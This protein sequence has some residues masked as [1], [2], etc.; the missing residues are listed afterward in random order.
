MPFARSRARQHGYSAGRSR[1]ATAARSRS[2]ATAHCCRITAAR[3]SRADELRA[4]LARQFARLRTSP[5][6]QFARV[7]VRRQCAS[8]RSH[9][10]RRSRSS[11]FALHEHGSS[12]DC[13]HADAAGPPDCGLRGRCSSPEL[14]LGPIRRIQRRVTGRPNVSLMPTRTC[15][16]TWVRHLAS[17]RTCVRH[18]SRSLGR[19]ATTCSA[20]SG[21]E[22]T[23]SRR[24]ILPRSNGHGHLGNWPLL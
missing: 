21:A 5:R 13:V 4:W 14:G 8:A 24:L 15:E 22:T 17:V 23:L 2:S 16:C 19:L 6:P 3:S 10:S 1:N 11:S 12:P 18:S 9:S 20:T 7:P